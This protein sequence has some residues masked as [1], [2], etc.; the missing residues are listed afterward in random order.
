MGSSIFRPLTTYEERDAEWLIDGWI[1][2]GCAGGFAADG[3]SGKTS[4]SC[5]ILA[6]VSAGKPLFFEDPEVK[7]E[8]MPVAFLAAE[9]SITTKLKRKLRLYGANMDNVFTPDLMSDGGKLLQRLRYGSPEIA[10]F[11]R[12]VKP[13]ICIFDPLQSF[14]PPELNMGS[15]NAMR[16]ALA[17][18]I[19]LGEETGCVFLVVAHTNKRQR[20]SGRDRIADSADFWD[21]SRFML[22][23]G[24]DTETGLHY[25]SQEKS[26]YG[27]LQKTKLFSIDNDGIIHG[28]GETWKRDREFQA[29]KENAASPSTR[30]DCKQWILE[31]LGQNGNRIPTARLDQAAKDDGYS[32]AT[33]RRAKDALKTDGEIRYTSTGNGKGKKEWYIERIIPGEPPF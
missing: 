5:H 17:P 2:K 30:D 22:M 21:I 25:L 14:L 9:D 7:R 26:N 4:L 19:A 8:P 27:E 15:R 3:G 16:N 33:L 11:V 20:A 28:E 10:L 31:Q 23:A 13:A 12:T 6:G 1:P 18:L 29:D 32:N 24:I